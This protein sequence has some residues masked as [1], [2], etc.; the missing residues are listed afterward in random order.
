M[1]Q[2]LRVTDLG[3]IDELHLVIGPGLTAIT[4]ETGAGKTLITGALALLAGERADAGIVRDGASEARV[5]GRFENADGEEVVLARVVPATGRSRAYVDGRLATAA[6]LSAHAMELLDLHAQHAHQALLEPAAQRRILDTYA[7]PP[8][9]TA[10]DEY[11]SARARL[12]DIDRELEALGGDTR[13]RAREISLLEFQI[14]ELTAADLDDPDEDRTLDV[15]EQ[16][17]ADAVGL[18]EAVAQARTLIDGGVADGIGEALAALGHRDPLAAVEARVRSLQAEVSD[19]THELRAHHELLVDDP[20]R[21]DAIRVRRQLFRDLGRKYGVDLNEVIAFR[22]EAVER[23]ALLRGHDERVAAL[24]AAREEALVAVDLAAGRLRAART[25]AAE[26]LA[27]AVTEQLA[28][29]AMPGAWIGIEIAPGEFGDDGADEVTMVLAANPGEPPGPLAKVASG[30]ERS[31]ALLAVRVAAQTR[32]AVPAGRAL[33]FDEVDA[34]VGGEAGAA[35]GVALAG[36]A[37]TAQVLCVTHLAQVAACAQ[38]QVV[39][40]KGDVEGRT[41]ARAM[42]VDGEDRV[43]ELSRMLAGVEESDHARRHAAEL[44]ARSGA[45]A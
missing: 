31:R 22:D 41:V 44:L 12:N 32:G 34:G 43:G 18:R 5:E 36:L 20:E 10:L 40:R 37:E 17:L 9:E 26:P 16:Q 35:V 30:G 11:R 6:E 21:L 7:G 25:A 29:L 27:A 3:I 15:E 8:A 13:M 19:I 28:E 23:L 4:G 42:I 38:T 14:T 2:E 39:V 33:V 1:L 24:E 45:R